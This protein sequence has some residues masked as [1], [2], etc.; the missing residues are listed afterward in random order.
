VGKENMNSLSDRLSVAVV[1]EKFQRCGGVERRTLELASHLATAGHELHIYANRFEKSNSSGMTFHY[2]P[3][4]KIPRA[5]KPLSF[6]WFTSKIVGKRK[7]DLVHA[8][9]RVF[10][11]D[12]V[13]LGIGCHKAYLDALGINPRRSSDSWF[14]LA[15]LHLEERMFS[16]DKF[17]RGC[18]VITNSTRCRN[19]LLDFYSVP[20]EFIVVIHNGVD[21]QE[22]NP[23]SCAELRHESRS[24]LGFLPDDF[25]V[26]FVGPGF[27]R[28]GLD[29]FLRA[30]GR[31]QNRKDIKAL[32]IGSGQLEPYL[33]LASSL[34]IADR[35]SWVGSVSPQEIVKYYAVADAF[36]LPTRYDPFANSTMEALA[37]G[38]PVVTT[39]VNGVS[40]ILRDNESAFLIDVNDDEMLAERLCQL[41]DNLRLREQLGYAGR[42]AVEPYTWQRTAVE[43]MAVY[44]AV[45]RSRGLR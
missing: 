10:S 45:I 17:D 19:E 9:T 36:A 21:Q 43:T 31:L 12:V 26:L 29:V 39:V 32:V 44:D 24:R 16:P 40:E 5:L 27:H 3:M 14:H 13:T 6:A 34:E 4:L 22:F 33:R 42:R 35:V 23:Q 11:Y 28:K 30:L 38:L 7:H 37:C 8:Q 2:V 41:A 20:P 15:V 1:V 18:R 25:V